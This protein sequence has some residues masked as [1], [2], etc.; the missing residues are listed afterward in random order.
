MEING[1]L[2]KI[3]SIGILFGQPIK[4]MIKSP[5]NAKAKFT[6]TT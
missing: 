1:Y 4:T 6:L 5:I 3:K 2:F